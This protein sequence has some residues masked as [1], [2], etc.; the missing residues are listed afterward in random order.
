MPKHTQVLN[1]CWILISLILQGHGCEVW[2][3]ENNTVVA[4]LTFHPIDHVLIIASGNTLYFW[5]WSR[6]EPFAT[7]RTKHEYEKIR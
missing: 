5:D 7:A 4:S 6:P 1:N 3:T 2:E